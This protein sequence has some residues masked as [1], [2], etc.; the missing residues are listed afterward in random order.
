MRNT[1][2]EKRGHSTT[3]NPATTNDG[4]HTSAAVRGA[5]TSRLRHGFAMRIGDIL[6]D[7][8]ARIEMAARGAGA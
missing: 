3:S 1:T 7:V 8:M 2:N 6:P 5:S 4:K